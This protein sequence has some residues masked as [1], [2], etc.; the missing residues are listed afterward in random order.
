MSGKS[1]ED[2]EEV[3]KHIVMIAP[4]AAPEEFVVDYEAALWNAARLVFGVNIHGC[5]FHLL[6]CIYRKVQSLGLA[7]RYVNDPGTNIF[8][9][10]LMALIFMPVSHIRPQF[11]ILNA[12]SDPVLKDLCKYYDE[13]WLTSSVWSIEDTNNFLRPIRTNNDVEGWHLRLNNRAGRNDL[14][15]YLLLRLLRKEAQL[16]GV[17]ANFVRMGA[18]IRYQ[19]TN[20]K[21]YEAKI[22]KLWGQYCKGFAPRNRSPQSP[23]RDCEV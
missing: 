1:Q 3:L 15:F 2:Y 7:D 4:G 12:T 16:V 19:K 21:K 10:K 8:V 18:I 9:K 20:L 11:S 22:H 5:S 14:Q 17:T 6:Q 23:S 13:T